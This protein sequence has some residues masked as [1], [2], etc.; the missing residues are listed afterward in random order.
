MVKE[1]LGTPVLVNDV[2]CFTFLFLYSCLGYLEK[3]FVNASEEIHIWKSNVK[4]NWSGNMDAKLGR[5]P[6]SCQL[7]VYDLHGNDTM[8]SVTPEMLIE[9]IKEVTVKQLVADSDSNT[10]FTLYKL[11]LINDL[12]RTLCDDKTAKQEVLEDGDCALLIKAR[13][14]KQPV[15][16]L[17]K[18][19]IVSHEGPSQSAI[20]R[21]TEGLPSLNGAN[22]DK[23]LLSMSEQSASSASQ[24][25]QT[26]RRV[27]LALLE[28]SYKFVD[29]ENDDVEEQSRPAEVVEDNKL[30]P[31]IDMG[32]SRRH[33][34]K[35]M[36]LNRMDQSLAAEWLLNN[37]DSLSDSEPGPSQM[38]TDEQMDTSV[39][40]PRRRGRGFKPNPSHLAVLLDMGFSKEESIQALK[41]NGNNPNTACDW[42]L[43]DRKMDSDDE[44]ADEPLNPE[45]E[46][47]KALITNPTIHIG[48]HDKKVLEAL[49]DMVENPWRRNNW[50]YES[51]VGNVI[52]Q[53]L[54]LYNKYSTTAPST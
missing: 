5:L 7:A 26:L 12:P 23:P 35:A 31:L 27:L 8:V 18:D 43:S 25:E 53:I 2:S 42:L 13:S 11:V 54:K 22:A 32:F 45:S 30:R 48:L 41:L 21:A 15:S 36:I 38:S 40:K 16:S 10:N 46:L 37:R 49:E 47:Y 50:A 3:L 29:F 20:A 14:S 51:A 52:L 24:V 39:P 34:E 4:W 9:K 33:A 28:L 44:T 19:G 17:V 1:S 6:A